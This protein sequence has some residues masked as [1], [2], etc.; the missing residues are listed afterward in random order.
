MIAR[1]FVSAVLVLLALAGAA[2]GTPEMTY[3]DGLVAL[4]YYD[5]AV[6]Q[7]TAMRARTDV[8]EEDKP[9][10]PLRLAN[11]YNLLAQR[12]ADPA[13][14]EKLIND[15]AALLDEFTKKFPSSPR[16]LDVK[17]QQADLL[18]SRGMSAEMKLAAEPDA[19]KKPP[20]LKDAEDVYA[21]GL[22]A[23]QDVADQC[24]KTAKDLRKKIGDVK[25]AEEDFWAQY[26]A[27]SR[28]MFLVGHLH[29]LQA[30]LYPADNPE[31][32]KHLDAA[33]K[34]F[35]ELAKLRPQTNVTF[36]A[37]TR[38]GICL[39][40]L[41]ALDK[42]PEDALA[43]MRAALKAF[44]MAL[45]VAPAD[46]TSRTR[47][48]ANYQKAVTAF[49]RQMYD[50]A[51]AAADAFVDECPEGK[52][53][54]HVQEGVLLRA[55]ALGKQAEGQMTR[56][57]RGWE[58]T[59]AEARRSIRDV[60]PAWPA[61]VQ[62]ADKLVQDWAGIFPGREEA[63]SPLGAAAEAKKLLQ[64]G[65]ADEALAKY[66]L[67][68]TLSGVGEDYAAFAQDAWKTI[69]KIHWDAKR[70]YM[71]A[72]AWQELARRYPA[73]AQ[74]AEFAWVVPQI[75]AYTYTSGRKD[76]FDF[77]ARLDSLRFFL[78]KFPKDP[79]AYEAQAQCAGTNASRGD[80]AKAA[81]VW[82]KTDPSS[83]RYVENLMKGAE[84]YR[85]AYAKAAGN[86]A[87]ADEAKR[88]FAECV[89]ALRAAADAK[90][91][92]SV[93]ALARLAEVLA[94]PASPQPESS[95]RV[96]GLVAEFRARFKED[97]AEL[98]R[99]L[100]AG[101]RALVTL[102]KPDEAEKIA[103]DIEKQFPKSEALASAAKLM[104]A[105][106]EKSNAAKAEEWRKK[107]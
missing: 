26:A 81:E 59:Y 64:A 93:K 84:F 22:L 67:V 88:C 90:E 103:L 71:A 12:E 49:D 20:L 69:G 87:T 18:A 65:K 31:K 24:G 77:E 10:V 104:A 42:K 95:E 25:G 40:E 34:Q 62:A 45:G 14:R 97:R 56:M 2:S 30:R 13:A 51:A 36:E 48:E 102:D 15:S 52:E 3:V 50:V 46:E 29:Y 94:D 8:A 98:P 35:E 99:A 4:G 37:F 89:R 54:L 55:R 33:Q 91:S 63:V 85:A 43:R 83:P 57:E 41:S 5:L 58:Q 47:A 17:I 16:V 1:S 92:R 80:P 11:L 60:S 100:L 105:G 76:A 9:L 82:V 53:S 28:A 32:A 68:I 19:K 61:V 107:Q 27:Q 73:A 6:E 7:L 72:I 38:Q 74:S 66:Q 39:R 79:R 75:Y 96:A 21:K 101:V 44:D 70:W 106:F 78:A 86:A 23:A